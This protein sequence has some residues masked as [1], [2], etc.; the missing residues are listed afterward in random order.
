MKRKKSKTVK[1]ALRFRMLDKGKETLYLDYYPAV[2]D[3]E[4]GK[5]SRREYLGMYVFPL[6][7]R[8]GELQTNKDGSHKYNPTDNETIRI[9]E[10]IRNNRQNELDKSNIYT[11]TE[12][13]L[14]KAKERS[15][16]DFIQY[17][18]KLSDEKREANQ[19]NWSAALKHLKNYTLKTDKADTIRFCDITLQWCEGFKNYL[20]TLETRENITLAT[21]TAAAYFIKFKI[22]LKS[23]HRYG[24]LPKNIN[25][26]LKSIKE[27][28]TRREFLTLD[29]LNTL[30]ITPCTNDL[31]KRAALFSALT[32]L[33][34][35][36]I[37]KMKWNEIQENNG[38]FTL[39]YIIQKTNKYQEL[40]ISAQA[41]Q[42]C[43]ERS[44][45]D[46]PVFEGLQYSAY[47]NKALA[48]WIGAAGI[49]R[50]ITFHCFRHTFATLQLASGTQITTIQKMLG[51][52]DI[53]T[54]MVYAKTLE[55]AKR[56]AS[57]KIK[58]NF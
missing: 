6:R 17:F 48:Q 57:E 23:A 19:D 18:K 14:L 4:T 30:A 32:G 2:I 15:K 21:N 3:P 44:N 29:E 9:A 45:P 38:L 27:V 22:A 12:A 53:A 54:T 26:D 25:Q 49:V 33:R 51:H 5:H 52:K 39:K 24:Y 56:E 8:N 28:E 1:V 40:P 16:G 50:N 7:K 47:A 11:E 55:E 43:G 42:L 20:L 10:I 31:L 35:S 37:I 36:D 58:L 46:K 34:H 41:V 13:E